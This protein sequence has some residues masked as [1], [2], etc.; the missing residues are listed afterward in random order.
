MSGDQ[1]WRTNEASTAEALAYC[2][3][4]LPRVSRTFALNIR[5]LPAALRDLV[6]QAY[7]FCRMADTV[8]DS[9]AL[10][11]Q[12]K[13]ARLQ[14]FAALFPLD[15]AWRGPVAAWSSHFAGLEA[16]GDDHALCAR[17]PQ[18]FQAF[19]TAPPDLR[20]P[21]EDCV[22]EMALGMRDYVLRRT[23]A[24]RGRLQLE[25][26]ADLERY[27]HVVAGTVGAML[28]RLFAA[29]SDWLDGQRQSR[30]AILAEHFALAMQLTNIIKDVADDA[31][32]GACF[33]PRA[34]I[35]RHSLAPEGLLDPRHREQARQVMSE[36]V[37]QAARA[38]DAALTFTLMIP[39][40]AVR[41]RLF[42]LWPIFLAAGT[43]QRVV[44]DDGLF[45]PGGRPRIGRDE[46]RRC[47]SQTT[48]LVWSDRGLQ[49]LYARRRAA[50]QAALAG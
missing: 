32:R 10:D 30:M 33:V 11:P 39:R 18:V 2:R 46:V 19:A 9:R 43:L 17:A 21:V 16:H 48:L 44:Q 24:P 35:S 38:L 29:T 23:R 37:Q 6:L 25:D 8:E 3:A 28:V 13:P 36:L 34:L 7:L 50:L 31:L 26:A 42:C 15:E 12:A 49:R 20:G 14:E 40:R 45:E 5:V 1:A 4:M 22:R 47:L 27:C 41:L